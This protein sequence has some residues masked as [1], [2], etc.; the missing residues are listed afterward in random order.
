MKQFNKTLYYILNFTWGIIMNIFGAVGAC[1]MLAQGKK[2]TRHGGSIMFTTGSGW[3]GVSL[4]IFSFVCKEASKHT[5][6]HEYG[7]SLQNAVYGPL[8]PFIVAIPSFI[9]YHYRDAQEKKGIKPTTGYDDIWF[10][11][12]ATDWG[13]KTID[14]W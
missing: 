2:P 13:T 12:Q 9:R 1:V 11:G 8:F 4:G 5:K 14:K 7:H 6:D 3:G 10:E